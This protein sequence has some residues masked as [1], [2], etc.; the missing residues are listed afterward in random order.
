MFGNSAAT[1][2]VYEVTAS[3]NVPSV[4]APSGGCSFICDLS[5]WPGMTA[6][7]EGGS[8]TSPCL[9]QAGTDSCIAPGSECQAFPGE[10]N[11]DA[12]W[13]L[14]GSSN[15]GTQY[16]QNFPVKASD[17]MFVDI[18][19]EAAGGG[20]VNQYEIYIDD[21]TS[22]LQCSPSNQPITFSMGTPYYGDFIGEN[23]AGG[24]LPN[25]GS[26]SMTGSIYYSG[27]LQSIYN[28]YSN[29]WYDLEL[30]WPSGCNQN[31][32]T[33]GTVNSGGTFTQT[34]NN[35]CGT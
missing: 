29:Y 1:N 19:N 35:S 22:G 4:T 3:W 28:P 21:F 26:F 5:I 31:D 16:C 24:T 27:A 15:P 30:L 2:P 12:W 10:N 25:F 9:I 23:A 20:N 13:E 32:I 34:Y 8:C 11:Y 6:Q 18:Y 14:L 33:V 17:S 7:D